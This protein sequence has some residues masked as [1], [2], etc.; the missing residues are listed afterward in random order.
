[1]KKSFII[2]LNKTYLRV[3]KYCITFIILIWIF[4]SCKKELV[5][6]PKSLAVENFYKTSAEIEAAVNA[7]YV[8]LRDPSVNGM[9]VYIAVLEAQTDY[10][11]GRG[12]YAVLN[13]FQGNNSVITT[14][15]SGVWQGFYLS[16]RNAN[17]VI[18]NAPNAT[19]LSQA[20]INQY[21]AEAKFLRAF[22]YFNLV[23]N[24]GGV[25]LRT[26][27]NMT[28]TDLKRSP[29]DS[30]YNLI[31]SDLNDAE[32]NLPDNSVDAGR[33]SKWA[34]K[35]MLA[36][37][38]L[39]INMFS[40]ARDKAEEVIQSNKYSLV[41]INTVDDFQNIFGPNVITTPEEIFYLKFSHIAG[42]G[43]LWPALLNHPATG[44]LG[45]GGVYGIYGD[46]TSPFFQTWDNNDLRKGLWYTWNIGVGPSTVLSK[47][48]IDPASINSGLSGAGLAGAA[49]SLP[50]YRYADLLLIYAEASDRA[51]SGPSP[52]GMEALNEVHRRGYGMDP[53]KPS[54]V[55]FQL[56]NYN[57]DSFLDLVIRER[58]YEFNLE[59]KRWM[60]LRRTGKAAEI[61]MAAKGK[62]IAAKAYLWPI[63][64]AEL[65]FNKALDPTK[66][67]N[68]GY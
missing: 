60:E 31:I 16:I 20:D 2:Y 13:T 50:W 64:A 26:E 3:F 1:M 7:I 65:N 46:S 10:S 43:D 47:K 38:Y 35:T 5:E 49:N 14:R 63:P 44:L 24:W 28:E 8:P 40:E 25:P 27:E 19:S 54:P 12:S 57:G 48:F 30:V 53:T 36:D 15:I 52:E 56:S 39:Q 61:I 17:L 55:D 22:S 23:R 58:G 45:G 32:T 33:P 34:A 18:K 42:Q 59:G 6:A 41:P 67:Q 37:V 66:D 29:T 51:N 68:P 4:P 11:Y 21:V 9:G 62:T